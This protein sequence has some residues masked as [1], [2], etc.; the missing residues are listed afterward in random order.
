MAD[1]DL[2]EA[3]EPAVPAVP[4][5]SRPRLLLIEDE[6]EFAGLLAGEL[7]A[8]GYDV[9]Q[10]LDGHSGLHRAL[11]RRYDVL[12]VDWGLPAIDGVDLLARLR[13]RGVVTPALMLTARTGVADRVTGL[14]AGA[15]DY[16]GKPFSIEELLAR[17]R[18]LRRSHRGTA[19]LL[20]L[21][22]AHRLDLATCMVRRRDET[23][24]GG[25]ELS[26][27]ECDLLAA[28][29]MRPDRVVSR[30]ELAALVFPGAGGCGAVDVYIHYLRRKL[31]RSVVRTVRGLGFQLGRVGR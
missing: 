7:G 30:D 5:V 18:S 19:S 21:P 6:R 27:R 11:T 22:P 13:R 14:D 28:L 16:L 2:G 3:V 25:L 29:A 26:G 15:E 9:D 24:A 23:A 4:A 17:L 12:V 31:G 1:D 10:A 8:A 20:P